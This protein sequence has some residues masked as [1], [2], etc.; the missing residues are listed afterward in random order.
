MK[1]IKL[2]SVCQP[3]YIQQPSLVNFSQSTHKTVN[4]KRTAISTLRESL[5]WHLL[6]RSE[7]EQSSWI[8]T[9][10]R[11][12]VSVQDA[13]SSACSAWVRDWNAIKYFLRRCVPET[14]RRKKQRSNQQNHS[15][16]KEGLGSSAADINNVLQLL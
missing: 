10:P 9:G 6:C 16:K 12:P 15:S 1:S 4:F 13:H 11:S 7:N 2:L 5:L 8:M 14:F 3:K